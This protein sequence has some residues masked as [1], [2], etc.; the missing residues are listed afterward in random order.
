[1]PLSCAVAPFADQRGVCRVCGITLTGRRTA[2]CS[3]RHRL[4]WWN[5]HDWKAARRLAVERD[6]GVCQRCGVTTRSMWDRRW[7]AHPNAPVEP[8]YDSARTSEPGYRE[9]WQR[10]YKNWHDSWEAFLRDFALDLAPEVNHIEPR[11]GKGYGMGC[12]NHADNLETLCHSCHV[13]VT[14]SQRNLR[15][16]AVRS[17]Q[18]A[19]SSP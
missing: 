19:T 4:I 3:D 14:E 13:E 11:S 6:A 8:K 1:M 12:H 9:E 10:A 15:R 2:W 18:T 17:P 7:R 16:L 5:Q